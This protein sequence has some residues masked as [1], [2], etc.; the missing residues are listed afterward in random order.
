MIFREFGQKG[1][2]TIILLHGG[3]LSYWSLNN[4]VKN[5]V[6]D[7]HVITPI[8]DGHGDDWDNTFISIEDSATKLIQYIDDV[9]N[10]QVFAIGGLSIGAQI[11]LE[12]LSKR[13]SIA[14]YAIVESA[15]VYQ[16]K[17]ISTLTGLTYKLLYGLVKK[18]WFAK[19]QAKSLSVPN[20][21]F[22]KYFEDSR[23][24]SRQSLVNISLSSGSY[25]LKDS[26]QNTKTN[27]LIIVGEKELNLI[28]KSGKLLEE[29]IP[30]SKL[31]VAKNMGHGEMSL[32]NYEQYLRVVRRFI[33]GQELTE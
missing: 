7:Y 4:V 19:M 28:V 32:V 23:R 14:K 24:M 27:V 30:D 22:E 16:I 21:M 9:H 31:Y 12:T 10:G 6:D 2:P 15:L 13:E 5:L 26:I 33:E 1:L 8:L 18:R 3:G 11:V 25:K 20:D 29:Y 17:G